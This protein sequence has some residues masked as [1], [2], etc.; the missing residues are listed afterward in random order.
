M[1]LFW[2]LCNKNKTRFR[3]AKIVTTV[4]NSNLYQPNKG[5]SYLI[6]LFWKKNQIITRKV[7]KKRKLYTLQNDLFS[8]IIVTVVISDDGGIS[9]FCLVTDKI[10]K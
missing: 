3:W 7:K 5:L 8:F 1:F 6:A 4:F 9:G 10:N 2:S